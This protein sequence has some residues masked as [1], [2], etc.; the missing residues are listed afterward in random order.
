ME[1]R[2][3]KNG[4]SAT[5]Y[6]IIVKGHLD[7]RRVHWFEGLTLTPLPSGETQIA[8]E[9]PDEAALHGILTRIRDLGLTLLRLERQ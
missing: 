8:G 2:Q 3:D 6:E 1:S 4:D 9:L 5:C 7:P